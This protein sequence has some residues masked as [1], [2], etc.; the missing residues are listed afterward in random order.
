MKDLYETAKESGTGVH[1]L[2][3]KNLMY[4]AS[5]QCVTHLLSVA[6]RSDGGH[7]Q[8]NEE[9]EAFAEA[10]RISEQFYGPNG[11]I[12]PS[13]EPVET[14]K[15]VDHLLGANQCMETIREMLF[16]GIPLYPAEVIC[17]RKMKIWEPKPEE[18]AEIQEG[19]RDVDII[20]SDEK[21]IESLKEGKRGYAD[22]VSRNK[23]KACALYKEMAQDHEF[24]QN[25]DEHEDYPEW[26]KLSFDSAMEY[27]KKGCLSIHNPIR[28]H[29]AR[30]ERKQLLMLIKS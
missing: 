6:N 24:K 25:Y 7:L 12:E 4:N 9:A 28:M 26:V 17:N 14:D 20:M 23:D 19:N 29:E 8:S 1:K 16:E 27:T 5:K 30:S 13:G 2:I 21:V 15:Y 10:A 3:A 11:L 22:F 18:V